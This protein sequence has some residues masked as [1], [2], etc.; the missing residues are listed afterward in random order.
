MIHKIL[1]LE[2]INN[3]SEINYI[4]NFSKI[5]NIHI[6]SPSLIK[7]SDL[8]SRE[9]YFIKFKESL[10]NNKFILKV[11]LSEKGFINISLKIFELMKFLEK[12]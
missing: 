10:K 9:K 11:E 12:Y 7:I 8:K 1:N 3:S 5:E 6:Q 2:K 4:F